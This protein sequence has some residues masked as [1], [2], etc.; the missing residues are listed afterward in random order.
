LNYREID[1]AIPQSVYFLSPPGR[2]GFTT[3]VNRGKR[4]TGDSQHTSTE[5]GAV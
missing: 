1:S 4:E 2:E 5:T 3:V